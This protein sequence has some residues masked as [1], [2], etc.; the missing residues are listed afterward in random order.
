MK[1]KKGLGLLGVLFA[2]TLVACN[3]PASQPADGSQGEEGQV[4]SA[5]PDSKP[6]SKPQEQKI[7]ITA[8]GGKKTL[9]IGEEVQL[10][11]DV[12]GVTW[13]SAK[14][15]V[16]TVSG[17]GLVKAI[18]PGSATIKAIKE[19]YKDGS[20]SI[21]VQKPAAPH[22]PEPTWP[23]LCPDVIDTTSWTAGTAVK[24]SYDKE[25]IPLTGPD[26]S[27]GV[28]MALKDS[29]PASASTF[30]ADGKLGTDA[31]S[32][33]TFKLKAPK[34]GV[35]QMILKASCSSSG[36]DYKFAG[37]SSRGFDVKINGYEDQDN[38]YGDRLYTDAGLNHDTKEA[39]V[40]ALVQLNGPDYEDEIQFRNPYYR[41]KFDVN[42]DIVFAENK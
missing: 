21:T 22:L 29:D 9:E 27:V 24:N 31:D 1:M 37:S 42:S 6:S 14:P 36:D 39:F 26:G 4:S 2:F 10:S 18:A 30:D 12:E 5:A 23:E 19:G 8:E 3:S 41:M 34:A 20:I 11:S 35:Y 28:K 33:V 25:Y 13:E 32:Y 38:V 40:F 16:A 17:A 15:E 7:T